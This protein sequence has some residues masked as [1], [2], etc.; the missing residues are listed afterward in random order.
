MT[1]ACSSIDVRRIG[2]AP[3][4]IVGLMPDVGVVVGDLVEM[5]VDAIV[6][7]ANEQLLAGGG[8]CGAI[9]RAAGHSELQRACDAVAPC[10]M[11]EARIT[12]GF[13]L[14]ARHVIH[15]VGPV[16]HGGSAGEQELLASAYGASLEMAKANG[17]ASVAFPAIST[18]VFGYPFE[19]ATSVAV[20]AV[21][22]ALH[23]PS[24][25]QRIVFVVR[26]ARSAEAYEQA[27]KA[28]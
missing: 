25:L 28:R 19:A 2:G 7:A 14:P 15:T 6:N 11:G 22:A 27:L 1:G 24:S 21:R 3:L 5:D 23:E 18:G 13:R 4:A 17:L 26:D 16:W 12:P 10:P 8:V 9:F 20:T